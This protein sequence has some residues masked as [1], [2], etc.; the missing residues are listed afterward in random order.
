MAGFD[1]QRPDTYTRFFEQ[2]YLTVNNLGSRF[3]DWLV[4]DVNPD[5]HFHFRT[6]ANEF[7]MIDDQAQ[8]PVI[9]RYGK[10][11]ELIERLRFAGPTREI[12]R[13]LQRYTVN[14]PIRIVDRMLAD[15]TLEKIDHPKARDMIIQSCLRLYN[16]RVGLD[17]YSENLPVEDL[18]I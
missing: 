4:R 5:L 3:D 12:M 17:V 9:V 8:R 15:R 7:K 1:P 14:L 18:Y 13:A 11:D 2:F 6:A 16:K 10:S